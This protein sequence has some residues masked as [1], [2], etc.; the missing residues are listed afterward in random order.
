MSSRNYKGRHQLRR[1]VLALSL[2]LGLG[3]ASIGAMAQSTTGS[4]FGRVP[5]TSGATVVVQN[6]N[7]GQ[8][9][10]TSVDSSGRYRFASLPAGTYN[11]TLRDNGEVVSTR[12]NVAV[13]I[14]GGTEVSFG[15]ADDAQ[16]LEGISVVA[17]A[18]PAIDV[19][20]VDTKTVFTAE[21][22][23][24][25]SVGRNVTAVAMLA[26]GV[27]SSS[28]YGGVPSFGGAAASENAYYV[29][30]FPVTNPLT[31]LGF[32][33]LPFDSIDQ[34][35]VITGGYGAAYGRATGGVTNVTTKRGGNQ[36]K[37]GGMMFWEPESLRANPRNFH[38]PNTGLYPDTDGT[39]YQ[40]ANQNQYWRTTYG[41]YVSGPLIKD[42]LFVYASAEMQKREGNSIRTIASSNVGYNDY[43]YKIPQ[44]VAKV[45]WNITDNHIVEFTALSDKTT[46]DAKYTGF[47]YDDFSHDNIQAG[48]IHQKDGG[49][50]YI[51][52]YTGYLTDNLT[53][54]TQ[55]GQTKI[56]HLQAPWG[57]DPS[58]PFVSNWNNPAIQAPGITYNQPCQTASTSPLPG[59][60]DKVKAWRADLEYHI[61]DHDIRL[62][63]DSNEARSYTGSEYAGGFVWVY[64]YTD[65]P[66]AA[67][68]AGHGVGSP[69]SAGGSGDDGYFVRRQYYTQVADV[70]VK[71]QAQYI[72][73]RWQITDRWLLQL[74]L[75]NE[76]FSN[77]DGNN[78]RYVAQRH[79][80]APRVGL[81]WDVFGDSS[82][83]LFANAG[84]YHLALPN[85]VA[86]RA[87]SASLYTVEYFTYT[88]T[89]P[90]TGAPTGLVNIPVDT[91]LG[92]SCPGNPTAI[93]SNLE[94]GIAPDPKTVAAKDLKSHFQDEY[95]IGMEQQISDSFNWGIKGTYR[96]L[97]SAID[98]TCTPAL[99]GRCFTF[100]P[101]V[102]NTFAF[103][104]EDGSY[105]YVTLTNEEL[106]FP[107]LKR[108]YTAVDLYL[109]HPFNDTWYGKL[110]YTWSH[111]YGNTEGQLLSDIDVGSGGQSDVSQTQDWDLPQLMVGSNGN[112][113][114]D[115]RHQ[116]KFFGYYQM[117][118]EWRFGT[119]GIISSGRPLSCMSFYPTA[120]AGLYNGA[121]YHFC[122]LAGSGTNPDSAGYIPPS[123][124]YKYSPRGAA[125][126]TPWTYQLNLN[127][128]YEPAW[129]PGLSLGVDVLNV[130][131]Q[132]RPQWY[133]TQYAADRVTPS[134][135][136]HQELNYTAPRQVRFTARYDFSL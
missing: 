132:Q 103:D 56:E 65:D 48:G 3:V 35:Q 112:L 88:G 71:Q 90:R 120:D 53:F 7:T 108:R 124:D 102:K 79:Q 87:A 91:S 59:A 78:Q 19:S 37:F 68:D 33:S 82:M 34:M 113:P 136:Y 111:N 6:V 60:N 31:N 47:D 8:E 13:T 14:A 81:S 44:W 9:L 77:Y 131:N 101:G 24:K 107:Q 45:D 134:R 42:R 117:T 127:A 97:R 28:S 57:F 83:K 27:V 110:E 96:D 1:T 55:Y 95:I 105:E 58:C 20:A 72:E 51:G 32:S 129:A 123:S 99:G 69:A 130:L 133:D 84:R 36:W 104:Q 122:G 100:N 21:E 106:G 92:Y 126:R 115:R 10:T 52:K 62:G 86:V 67:V 135:Y 128:V 22:L 61:G 23:S 70:Q 66:S 80:L 12:Q 40:Y 85:N 18:L 50:I 125:G 38:Y 17:S 25:I 93:S 73:D 94:C 89:D 41:A 119:S 109:E 30:G 43:S 16:V 29:N 121:Y 98:D 5:A 39:L 76:Q 49:E 54:T 74:G 75:R 46:Y 26:P 114:N 4:V 2:G 15:G 63:Y 118:P 64:M 116:V 11:V